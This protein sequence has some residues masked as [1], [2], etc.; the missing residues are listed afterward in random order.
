[1]KRT[2]Q[3]LK[4]V[5][6]LGLPN[7]Y[8]LTDGVAEVVVTTDVG[9]RVL[10]Y[11]LK[12]GE[13]ILGECAGERVETEW[14]VWRPYGGHRLWTA[15]EAKPRSYAPDNEPVSIEQLSEHAIRLKPPVEMRTGLQKEIMLALDGGGGVTLTHRIT[16]L[17]AWRVELA[18]WAL[19]IM[20]GGGTALIPQE[21]YGPHPECLLHAR[22]LVVW[23]Y[24]D[25][26][27]ARLSFG[28]K[29]ILVRS[30]A[31]AAEPQKIGVGN[32]RG[33]AAYMRGAS[34]FVKRFDYKEGAQYP[35]AGC[36]N[37]VFIASSFIELES[38][39]PLAAVEP[40]GTIE[41]VERWRL[42]EGVE[43][44]EGDEELYETIAPLAEQ[45]G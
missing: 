12:G 41:H 13:N 2:E 31:S 28:R 27:D 30:D 35:D 3:E 10:G 17:G 16:N 37:E 19:T 1:L 44:G 34:L 43:V 38:L 4:R 9:P 6:H 5:E 33:W 7:C 14:G 29:L 8:A 11:A 20:R 23:P 25:M 21:P 22:P 36:N 39:S 40:G 32:K 18:A 15:P 24:T 42:F 45:V 26:S